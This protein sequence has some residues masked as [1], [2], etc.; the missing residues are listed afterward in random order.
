MNPSPMTPAHPF[1]GPLFMTLAC[2]A[3]VVNDTLM[4][5]ATVGL[6]PY[7]VLTMRGIAAVGWGLPLLLA[8]GY[9]RQLPLMFERRVLTRNF[10]ELAAI[11]CYIVALANMPIADATALGQVTP[12]L[13]ILG[14]SLV[15]G[16]RIGAA[17][18]ALIGLGFVGAL[19]VAQPTGSGISIYALLALG[20]AVFT[21]V[22]DIVGRRIAAEVPGMVVALSAAVV[23][24]VGA[25]TWHLLFERWVWPDARH[26]WLLTGSG[27]FL[28]FGHFLIFMAYRIGP[29]HLVAPFFYTF[30]LWAMVSGLLVFGALPNPLA[31][32]GIALVVASGLAI[33][34]LDQRSRRPVPVA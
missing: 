26:V 5:L 30:T 22:R 25:A 6:P 13:V 19:M 27:L 28:I 34:L 11:L 8:L 7:Q 1:R 3:Y 18:M 20:T 33:V 23:V 4:K 32:A 2:G 12:L 9:G 31:I 17:R 15:L 16:E 29:T 24:L 10:C 14:A 21:A